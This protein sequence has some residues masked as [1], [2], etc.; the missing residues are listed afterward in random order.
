M[1]SKSGQNKKKSITVLSRQADRFY[2]SRCRDK[3]RHFLFIANTTKANPWTR[4]NQTN[5]IQQQT[6]PKMNAWTISAVHFNSRL[7]LPL[8]LSCFEI[9]ASRA[10]SRH[11]NHL[12]S[13]NNILTSKTWS[14]LHI[15]SDN[16]VTAPGSPYLEFLNSSFSTNQDLSLPER[17][18]TPSPMLENANSPYSST[19]R[20]GSSLSTTPRERILN[21]MF[22]RGSK[23]T[24]NTTSSSSPRISNKPATQ[25]TIA[26]SS[27]G[28]LSQ[29]AAT[30]EG[31]TGSLS[32]SMASSSPSAPK[33]ILKSKPQTQANPAPAIPPR[34]HQPQPS[35]PQ[36]GHLQYLL[37]NNN[38][39]NNSTNNSYNNMNHNQVQ[40]QFQSLPVPQQHQQ[41][42]QQHYPQ[43]LSTPLVFGSDLGR[44]ASPF[45]M[46]RSDSP[47]GGKLGTFDSTNTASLSSTHRSSKQLGSGIEP[48]YNMTE[49]DMTL[50][51][52]A[53]RWQSYQ[54]LMRKRYA[55][56]PFFKRWT[57]SKWMLLFSSLLMLGYSAVVLVV[58]VGY[59][60]GRKYSSACFFF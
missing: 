3:P 44:P 26:N 39:N 15:S 2:R 12:S 22:K 57:K 6:N 34:P 42:H 49:S 58:V 19:G 20:N 31:S 46:G 55:E 11:H 25:R 28:A 16:D 29:G 32:P 9:C 4:P 43:P 45:A 40:P 60:S 1:Q 10:I 23:E 59:K 51:G 33:S 35:Y 13:S 14:S 54:A 7:D 38:N 52:L 36:D 21:T 8:A 24:L 30:S 18:I 37:S 27:V 53:E 17:V 56:E 47:S 41:L 50:E 48:N 5:K